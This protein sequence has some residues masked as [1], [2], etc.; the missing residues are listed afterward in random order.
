MPKTQAQLDAHEA[1]I[2][3]ERK[4]A[5]QKLADLEAALAAGRITPASALARA[6]I[7]GCGFESKL[8]ELDA[9][10]AK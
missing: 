3:A 4:T 1:R 9:E 8:T 5:D 10:F 6:F 2:T 7:A